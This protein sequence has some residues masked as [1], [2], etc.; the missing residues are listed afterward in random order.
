M[1][2]FRR[3]S[4]PFTELEWLEQDAAHGHAVAQFQ[5]GMKYDEGKDVPKD[6]ARGLS[7]IQMAAEQGAAF[8]SNTLGTIYMGRGDLQ[9]G[10]KWTQKAAEQGLA[11]AQGM[12][13]ILYASGIAIPKDEIQACVW[14]T[15][16]AANDC[17]GDR[18]LLKKLASALSPQQRAEVEK[19]VVE[20]LVK[21]PRISF[22][23]H[24][25][26]LGLM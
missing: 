15:V 14:L 16:A 22:R 6:E 9:K 26:R 7:L 18:K 8:A 17:P 20:L 2:L 4:R 21:L 12:L 11:N 13:G 19:L 25:E 23:E 10:F 3:R 24:A 1:W 5:L